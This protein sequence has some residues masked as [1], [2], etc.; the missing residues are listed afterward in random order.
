MAGGDF[1]YN[2]LVR[3]HCLNGYGFVSQKSYIACS[4]HSTRR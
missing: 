1:W 4:A 2:S 3:G